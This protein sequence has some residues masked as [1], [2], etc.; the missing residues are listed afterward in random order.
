MFKLL[1][2]TWSYIGLTIRTRWWLHQN[3]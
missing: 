2:L 3:I 1:A